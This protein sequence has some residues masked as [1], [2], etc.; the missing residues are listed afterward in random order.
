MKTIILLSIFF[1]FNIETKNNLEIMNRNFYNF[2]RGID[3]YF[4]NSNVKIYEIIPKNIKN[5]IKTIFNLIEQI[6]DI[7]IKFIIKK[8]KFSNKQL[9]YEINTKKIILSKYIILPIIGPNLIKDHIILITY[10]FISLP[11]FYKNY[12]FFYI[13]YIIFKKYVTIYDI[14]FFHKN[15]IDGYTFLKYTLLQNKKYT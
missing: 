9:L 13:S 4:F 12:I 7:P 15:M 11:I 10:Q 2:N 3:K 8:K 6:Q 1:M 5:K 14:N